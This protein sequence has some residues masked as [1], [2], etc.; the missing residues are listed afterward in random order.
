MKI[1]VVS[2]E[3][4]DIHSHILHLIKDHGHEPVVFGALKSGHDESWVK[5][6]YEAALAVQSGQ[7]DEGIFF[8]WTGTGISIC[9]N[10]L[11]DIRAALCTDAETT[12]GARIWN[13][14]NVLA[15]SNRL[16]TEEL[17]KEILAVWFAEYDKQKGLKGVQE[18]QALED[19]LH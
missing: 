19:R 8:C 17:A 1:A 16:I 10:K 7:C 2:D 13:H 15:L 11:T 5:A 9:A 6:A 14:A 3:V 18:L 12:K 4:C